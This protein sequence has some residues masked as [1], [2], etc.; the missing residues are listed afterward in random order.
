MTETPK[1][2]V[3]K[4][5]AFRIE[6][7]EIDKKNSGLLPILTGKLDK[8][9]VKDRLMLLN[10]DDPKKEE[11]FISDFQAIGSN[12]LAGA[13]IRIMET[14]ETPSIPDSLF[15]EQKIVI[16]DLDSLDIGNA[17]VYKDHY[18]F[19]L[20]NN[21]VIT[22][23]AGNS[24][25]T[26]FQTYLNWLLVNERGDN[27]FEFTP[28]MTFREDISI[29][30]LKNIKIQDPIN[31][32]N[33]INKDKTKTEEVS[34]RKIFEVSKDYI[35]DLFRDVKSLD[36]IALEKIISAE[37]LI[38]FKK[39]KDV[40]KEEYQK[41]LGAYLKPISDTENVTF[42][43]KSG[44][45]INS[46]EILSTKTVKI[47]VTESNKISEPQ[48]FQEMEKYLNEIRSEYEN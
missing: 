36:N 1:P 22:N 48:L 45:P 31:I 9:K 37:L 40:S 21:Y 6:N 28:C 11:D 35:Y 30:E 7:K 24:T 20:N 16:S 34:T 23:L 4:L 2:R 19:L 27:L 33:P 42:I 46:S 44:K 13:M 18:Y 29:K 3:I 25:I 41:I 14:S 10:V 43:P 47:E 17:K 38:K 26:R 32:Q 8:T 12:F 5:R 15:N 39:S